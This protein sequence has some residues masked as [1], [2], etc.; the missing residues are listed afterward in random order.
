MFAILTLV[1]KQIVR[2]DSCVLCVLGFQFSYFLL[3]LQVSSSC[4]IFYASC[5]CVFSAFFD[6]LYLVH[7][8]LNSPSSL[9]YLCLCFSL[10]FCQ[11]IYFQPRV[12][13]TFFTRPPVLSRSPCHTYVSHLCTSCYPILYFQFLFTLFPANMACLCLWTYAWLLKLTFCLCELPVR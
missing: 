9:M 4:V 3:V 8:S 11:F 5:L 7:L 6:C 10:T 13:L 12:T 1:C 2:N